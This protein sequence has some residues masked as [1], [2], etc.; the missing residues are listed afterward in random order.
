MQI[1]IKKESLK[2]ISQILFKI[3]NK[4]FSRDFDLPSKDVA[5]QERYLKNSSVYV[6]Y[7][8]KTPIGFFA[9]EHK[10]NNEIEVKSIAVIPE[11]QKKGVGKLM[12]KKLLKLV[13]DYSVKTV[14][15]PYNTGAII[16]YL[17]HGFQ[18][19]GWKNNYYGDGQPRLLLKFDT[20]KD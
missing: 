9:Y 10:D 15:H 18:I 4:A 16:L 20:N 12:M 17:K 8:G 13:K 7:D 19:Y 3:D 5:E 11:Y 2:E 6:A 14:T 1:K